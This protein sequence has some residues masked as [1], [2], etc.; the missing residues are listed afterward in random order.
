MSLSAA[1]LMVLLIGVSAFVVTVMLATRRVVA[2]GVEMRQA[3]DRMNATTVTAALLGLGVGMWA[4]L[5][6]PTRFVGATEVPGLLAALGPS[7]AGLVF[8][9][10]TGV[11]E[12]TWRRPSGT[13]RAAHLA[14]RPLFSRAQPWAA[15][16]L[17]A[18]AALL[19]VAVV[20]FGVIAEPDGRSI[21]N[22]SLDGCMVDGVPVPCDFGASGPFPGW[23]Y[24]LPILLG[25]GTVLT[26]TL[27]VLYLVA[28]RPAVRG[29]STAEDDL[30]R[31][32]SATRVVRG[33]QLAIGVTLTGVA[34][35]AGAT[36]VNA[37]WWWGW[38]LLLLAV[39]VLGTSVGIAM[40]RVA[41]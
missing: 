29:T 18:W 21:G 15:R 3:M 38:A 14:R 32:V 34:F 40:R 26:A 16:A 22:A 27:G 28:R 11:G 35:F 4:W 6:L 5:A 19:G 25:A 7:L 23:P 2:S 31:T 13:Q 1:A 24:G 39:G 17:W 20:V 36:A 12:A 30:L 8:L 37:G 10:V 9:A 33:A 41:P